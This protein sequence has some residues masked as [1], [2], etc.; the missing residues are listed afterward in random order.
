MVKIVKT[1]IIIKL[2]Q[3]SEFMIICQLMCFLCR[4]TRTKETKRFFFV[5]VC[6]FLNN[7][8]IIK[9]A[10]SILVPYWTMKL[11]NSKTIKSIFTIY[12]APVP[13]IFASYVLYF[14]HIMKFVKS[15]E[16]HFSYQLTWPRYC[17]ILFDSR[18]V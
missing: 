14:Y 17:S 12:L 9:Q 1:Q 3:P 10:L 5:C 16:S 6:F 2:L 7:K 8:S 18:T 13:C 11:R 4:I 15:K